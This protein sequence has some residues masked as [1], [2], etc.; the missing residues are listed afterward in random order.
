MILL[1][2]F[3]LVFQMSA[4]QLRIYLYPYYF[5]QPVFHLLRS[6]HCSLPSL[7]SEERYSFSTF[8][9]DSSVLFDS[10]RILIC[11]R[12][13]SLSRFSPHSQTSYHVHS[14]HSYTSRPNRYSPARNR[15]SPFF[16]MLCSIPFY[17]YKV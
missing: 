4:T 7:I 14:N 15:H 6:L 9:R 13:V 12:F 5:L 8:N 16:P 3:E 11:P 1:T 2:A 17:L 10:N